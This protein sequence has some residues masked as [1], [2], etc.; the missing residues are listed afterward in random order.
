MNTNNNI[1]CNSYN[2]NFGAKLGNY[3]TFQLKY[4][5]NTE[6]LSRISEKLAGVGE[7]S[8][9]VE[10]MSQKTSKGKMYSLRLFNEIFSETYNTS[11]LKDNYNRDIVSHQPLDLLKILENISP[12]TILQKEHKVFNK[13]AQEHSGSLPMVKYLKNLIKNQK[14]DGKYLTP[15]VEQTYF[16]RFI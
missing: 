6:M 14:E 11:L 5:G 1:N 16:Q 9:V 4:S 15:D 8:T 10:V 7:P 12:K 13:V 2:P 3:A